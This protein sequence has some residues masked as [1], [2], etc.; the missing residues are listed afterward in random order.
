MT[1]DYEI[2][3]LKEKKNYLSKILK[4]NLSIPSP[5]LALAKIMRLYHQIT[6][7]VEHI[8]KYTIIR[9]TNP[10]FSA[11]KTL[12]PFLSFTAIPLREQK[13]QTAFIGN[14]MSQIGNICESVKKDDLKIL[15][16]ISSTAATSHVADTE[17]FASGQCD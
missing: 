7:M 2:G 14:I 15:F 4:Q 12:N 10:Q 9:T 13:S 3:K 17:H 6:K 8:L 11:F 16:M 5:N 1:R